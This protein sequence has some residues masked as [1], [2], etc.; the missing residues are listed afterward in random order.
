MSLLNLIS[1]RPLAI[2]INSNIMIIMLMFFMI[3]WRFFKVNIRI[4][5]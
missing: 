2:R 5:I 1:Y 3:S 4:L